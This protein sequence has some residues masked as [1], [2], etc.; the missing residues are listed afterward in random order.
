MEDRHNWKSRWEIWGHVK[1][2][3]LL[4]IQVGMSIVGHVTV[5]FRDEVQGVC[6]YI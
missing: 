6:G 4:D 5:E 1:S 2:G 3:I